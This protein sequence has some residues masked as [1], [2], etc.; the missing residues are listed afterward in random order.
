MFE[1][2]NLSDSQHTRSTH[3]SGGHFHRKMS[4]NQESTCI[5]P[6]ELSWKPKLLLLKRIISDT[7]RVSPLIKGVKTAMCKTTEK[8]GIKWEGQTTSL[9]FLDSKGKIKK[10]KRKGTPPIPLLSRTPSKGTGW[11]DAIS[12]TLAKVLPGRAGQDP[13]GPE[14]PCCPQGG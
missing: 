4:M 6:K 1:H 8:N 14:C 2:R 9:S 5:C 10:E 3:H 13:R 11:E 7:S 12:F